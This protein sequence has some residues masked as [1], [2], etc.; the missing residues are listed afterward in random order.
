MIGIIDPRNVLNDARLDD[1]DYGFDL[2]TVPSWN[3]KKLCPQNLAIVYNWRNGKS[4]PDDGIL[5]SAKETSPYPSSQQNT[6]WGAEVTLCNQGRT[7]DQCYLQKTG[8]LYIITAYDPKF[9]LLG[10][11]E[12][13]LK[14]LHGDTDKLNSTILVESL[15]QETFQSNRLKSLYPKW[16]ADYY[17]DF[18]DGEKFSMSKVLD[19]LSTKVGKL[20]T[21][22]RNLDY[23]VRVLCTSALWDSP[24][25]SKLV[26]EKYSVTLASTEKVVEE[27]P[28]K[29][30]KQAKAPSKSTGTLHQFFEKK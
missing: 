30:A 1:I 17:S 3:S 2:L 16:I 6:S 21:P 7:T 18:C 29:K 9:L 14:A 15:E 26:C 23:A 19:W 8:H 11:I 20:A 24:M 5:V 13:V 10:Y 12:R 22:G 28:V 25:F 27:K 4:Q